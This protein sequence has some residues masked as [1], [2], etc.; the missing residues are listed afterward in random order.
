MH[1]LGRL[2]RRLELSLGR[3]PLLREGPRDSVISATHGIP[4][5]SWAPVIFISS[6]SFSFTPANLGVTQA[7][8]V[9]PFTYVCC[10]VVARTTTPPVSLARAVRPER[11]R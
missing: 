4:L 2:R 8:E 7:R 5:S 1:Y 6:A 10:F 11:C 9:K 3:F